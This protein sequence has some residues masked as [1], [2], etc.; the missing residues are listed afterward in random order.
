MP[1]LSKK[2]PCHGR[3]D[4]RCQTH[5]QG[6]FHMEL[7]AG[8][9]ARHQTIAKGNFKAELAAAILAQRVLFFFFLFS[10]F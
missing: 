1:L 8:A 7:A 10:N 2:D 5:S 4:A 3:P 9:D 6:Q